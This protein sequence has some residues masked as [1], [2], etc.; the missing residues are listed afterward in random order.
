MNLRY[1]L[2]ALSLAIAAPRV[3]P[4]Q[5]R[6]AA[7]L[8]ELVQGLP[9]T[10]RVL[11]IG[12]HP[13]DEDTRLI[14]WLAL[15]HHA[16]VAYLSLTRGDGGQNL[17]GDELGDALGVIRTE[18]L[19]AARRIDGAHQY[20]TRAY[21]FGFSKTS[22]ESFE[23]WPH[24]SVLEDVVTV[25]RAF[26]P[27]V[28]VSVF[29]GTPRDGHGQHQ[30][31]GIVAR[32]AY[33]AAMDTVR[34]PRSATA[35]YG[36]W[37]PLKFYRTRSYWGGQGATLT[38]NAGAYDPLLGQSYAQIAAESRSQH[39]SQG[40]GR[41][42]QLGAQ[43]GSVRLESSR[44]RTASDP[45][46]ER[47]IFEGIDTTWRRLVPQVSRPADRAAVERVAAASEEA[48][49]TLRLADPATGVPALE[50]ARAALAQ[51]ATDARASS[52]AG[53]GDVMP[54]VEDGL[55]RVTR[56]LL[57]ARGITVEAI[58]PRDAVAVGDSI[59]VA[60]TVYD[61]G[62]SRVSVESPATAAMSRG[63]S[64]A[65]GSG[66]SRGGTIILPDSAHTD[67]T[68]VHGG[69]I[70]QPWWLVTPRRGDMFSVPIDGRSDDVRDAGTQVRVVLDG[71]A[72]VTDVPV[73]RRYADPVRG[74]L[75]RPVAV[76]PP[77]AVTLDRTVELAR[78]N[79]PLSRSVQVHLVSGV[80]T[81]R[82]VSVSL[83]LPAGL[84]ADS[85]ARDV[86]LPGFGA[87]ATVTFDVTGQLAP[88]SYQVAAVARSGDQAFTVG[89]VPIEYSHIRPQKL[90]RPAIVD[91][92]VVDAALPPRLDVGYVRGVGDNVAPML[93]ELGVP[94]TLLDPARLATVDL[95]R[96]SAIVIGTRA[97]EAHPE[98][99]AANGRLLDWVRSGGTMV[100]QYGQVEM[101][102]PGRLPYPI[103]LTR[104]AAR[105][106]DEK[107]VVRIL[108]PNDPVL[109]WPNRIGAA[110]WDGWVQERAL[111]MPST[112]DPRY[113]T[114]IAM[115]DP[116]ETSNNGAILE[117]RWGAGMYVYTT[118]S[119]FRQLP[120][121]NPGASRL[122]LNMLGVNQAPRA[123]GTDSTP[124]P[125]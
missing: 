5:S 6:G 33:D 83:T 39:K 62:S 36:A 125:R 124:N 93:Q 29:S 64:P 41:L 27:Q 109:N 17:I 2:A 76:V 34:F 48:R 11:V 70:T 102:D 45:S 32:E 107:A 103:E 123:A 47:S 120:A 52:R 113:I 110:D 60:V 90:Y 79:S 7:A 87:A 86:H 85:A 57:L 95:S 121:G 54:S 22:A 84:H 74:E 119:L 69:S 98:L 88:G 18:E 59:P 46:K 42:G 96:Y 9:V 68:W 53:G 72:L 82:D 122:F 51:L 67:T 26:R 24:D 1:A 117:A 61:Q 94:I 49:R 15:G 106:T 10:V 115:N 50:R 58:A 91:L 111:Y 55:R 14:T 89:Y 97:Y 105:V 43:T 100:V 116:D 71:G 118:L 37:T 19:L 44:V 23:H 81:P 28:I 108:R 31:A 3:L 38:Y 21:D 77:V 114:P 112:I 4:A 73:V 12:A 92:H 35:G 16:D 80:T 63:G 101:T 104:P 20:F 78:A 75:E 56:A 99:A 8:G 25:V 13:D 66:P 40:F 30:V 65:A